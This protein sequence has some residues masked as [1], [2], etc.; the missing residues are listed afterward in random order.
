M[1]ER[2]GDENIWTRNECESNLGCVP[3]YLQSVSHIHSKRSNTDQ[4]LGMW[5]D[6]VKGTVHT[7]LRVVS[8]CEVRDAIAVCCHNSSAA[9]W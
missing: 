5:P 7:F 1:L 9:G 2:S 8:Q 4:Q 6:P 3:Y